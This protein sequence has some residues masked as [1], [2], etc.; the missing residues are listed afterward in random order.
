M[1][2]VITEKQRLVIDI[3]SCNLP[4]NLKLKIE[5]EN[6]QTKVCAWSSRGSEPPQKSGTHQGKTKL[7][8][9]MKV[10]ED[11][12]HTILNILHY[13]LMPATK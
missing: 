9:F 7:A 13:P 8:V 2:S 1:I 6:K 5:K 11:T 3:T 10:T 4:T 12:S